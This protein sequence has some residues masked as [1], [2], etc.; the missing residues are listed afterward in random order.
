[1]LVIALIAVLVMMSWRGYG[2][3]VKKADSVACATKMRNFG[4]A[5]KNH[6]IDRQTWPQEDVLADANGNPPP[7]NRLW[8]WWCKEMKQFGVSRDDWYCPSEL[9]KNPNKTKMEDEDDGESEAGF[10]PEI[11]DPSYIPSKFGFGTVKP[12]Q[13][14]Q[15]WV[16]ESADWHGTGMNKLMPDLSIQKEFS[17]EAIKQM[18]MG[19]PSK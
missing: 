9:R 11:K 17:F 5:L 12:Y 13:S 6:M 10:K 15:P 14:N 16:I 18:R 4:V 2:V 1:M 7:Q 8:D 3:Y 19:G